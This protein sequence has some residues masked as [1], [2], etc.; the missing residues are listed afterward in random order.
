[1]DALWNALQ[2]GGI[3]S[4]LILIGGIVVGI[5]VLRIVF[6]VADVAI[7]VG[8]FALFVL[9]IAWLLYTIFGG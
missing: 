2:Q 6:E 3:E 5:I 1:M 7:K 8:C 9:G 4:W